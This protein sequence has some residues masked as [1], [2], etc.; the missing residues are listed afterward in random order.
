MPFLA[1]PLQKL[2]YNI[3][4]EFGRGQRGDALEAAVEMRQGIETDFEGH[5]TDARMWIL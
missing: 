4:T 5:F 2:S 1:N 3:L